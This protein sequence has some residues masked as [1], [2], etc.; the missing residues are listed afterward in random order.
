MDKIQRSVE[1]V[2]NV[3]RTQAWCD[4][5][6]ESDVVAESRSVTSSHRDESLSNRLPACDTSAW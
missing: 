2:G 6:V 3:I 5:A 4:A 1:R